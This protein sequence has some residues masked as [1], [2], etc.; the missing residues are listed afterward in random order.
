[1]SK[2]DGKVAL[3]TGAGQ[4]IGRGIALA[5]AKEGVRI[6]AAGRTESKVI[7]TAEAIEELGGKA[8]A[9]RCDVSNPD[10]V[11]AAVQRT[12]EHFGGVD[13]L[14]NNANDCRP[15]PLLSFTDDEF[16]RSFATGP[17]A[18]LRLMRACYPVM[19]ERGGGSIVNLVTSAA[20]R[21]DASNYGVY[22]SIKEGM[23]SLTRA[24]AC[25]WGV[26]GIRVNA[27]APHALSPGLERWMERNPEE[28]EEFRAGIPLRRIGDPETDIG[29]A[30]V[31]FVG[32]DAG[33]LTGATIPLDGG[34]SRGG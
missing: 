26:D 9:V 20:V 2:L 11:D 28:A 29:R 25:E 16:E 3:I 12:V 21:W 31:F 13:I 24:A 34:Q 15:G 10:D 5:L 32:E 8:L 1:M 6:A 18:T 22:G 30:V 14:V 7:S 19:K 33:Y 27:I 23:R 17:L 4:G